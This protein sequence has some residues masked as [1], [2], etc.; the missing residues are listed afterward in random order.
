MLFHLKVETNNSYKELGQLLRFYRLREGYSLRDLGL[1]ARISHT[2][3]ANIEQGKV[4]GSDNTLR[5]LYNVLNVEFYDISD[6]RDEFVEIYDVAF[7]YLYKYEYTRAIVEMEK[8]LEKEEIYVHSALI[9]EYG[10]IKFF[11]Q[12]LL[13]KTTEDSSVCMNIYGRMK[14]NFSDRQLQL[15]HLIE[16]V[17]LYNEGKYVASQKSLYQ[18][19]T[20]GNSKLD[21][22]IKVYIVKCKVKTFSFMDVVQIGEETIDFFEDNV[23]YL[24]AMELRLSIAYS[25]ILVRKFKDAKS[26]LNNVYDFSTNFNAIY[27]IEETKL[28]L[29][30]LE[31]LVGN[32]EFAEEYLGSYKT[33]NTIIYFLL[34]RVAYENNDSKEVKRLYDEYLVFT[35]SRPKV[36]EDLLVQ[37]S[38]WEMGLVAYN[39][40]DY[41]ATIDKIIQLSEEANDI[42]VIDI[43][44][45]FLIRH[46]KKKRMYKKAF[47]ASER[48]RDIRRYGS[49]NC[50]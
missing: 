9:T 50:K 13:K 7:D 42:E 44:Y 8:L 24:R 47:E 20:V 35:E 30:A 45:N 31:L 39:E 1:L 5:E 48:A 33:R 32:I 10:L 21:Y 12:A 14:G 4:H 27:L 28:L 43:S 11:Y 17:N 23:I 26:L 29:G 41:L 22:L 6:L 46:Y 36:K 37:I 3:I 25:Y 19:L 15:F 38:I 18:A 2:F 34:M 40:Q 16:G 49:L